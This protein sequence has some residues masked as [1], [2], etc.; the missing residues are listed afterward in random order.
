M[1]SF[2]GSGCI[3]ATILRWTANIG[4]QR[5]LRSTVNQRF[6]GHT[7]VQ[8]SSKQ[9]S[10]NAQQ[11][12]GRAVVVMGLGRFGGGVGVTR[13]LAEQGAQVTVTDLFTEDQ[14][15]DALAPLRTLIDQQR[16]T[17][18]LGGHDEADFTRADLI[19]A[20]PAVPR[21]WTN[22]YLNA[23]R[24]AGAAITTEVRLLVERLNRQRVIGV[25]GTAGKSTTAAMIHHALNR[26]GR[27][28]HLGGNIGGS[29]LNELGS[30]QDDDRIVLELSSAMLYWL[31]AGN[32]GHG[33][34]GWSP[35]CAVITNIAPNHLDWHESFEHY[36]RCK[37]NIARW[38]QTGDVLIRGDDLHD[39]V[40]PLQLAIPGPHN[41]TNARTAIAVVQSVIDVDAEA[42]AIA[43]GDFRGLPHRLQLVREANGLRVYN[44]SKSTTPEATLRAIESFDDPQ[45]IHLIAGGYDKGVDLSPIARLSS[46]LAGVYTIGQTGAAIA[47][48]AGSASNV[49]AC[50]DLQ[51]A[52]QQA[53]SRMKE[54]DLLLLSPGCASW[55][56][57]VNFEQRGDAF[58]KHVNEHLERGA[59]G[60]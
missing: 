35:S 38:Q 54:G 53:M 28:A 13:W 47:N 21:P 37:M 36:R 18:R 26:L 19:V 30:I 24:Q 11:L 5:H 23:A 59:C 55:D 45:H 39:D 15:A 4:Q 16:L 34:A 1:A 50:G 57:F 14:L 58:I 29:L 33:A 10:S 22:R 46:R 6:T 49:Q 17:L 9:R 8:C 56:Q 60:A 2:A 7:A 25:T 41:V 3:G 12:A 32:G 52:V 48:A 27:R 44:D 42:V 43:L 31:G 20:N 51:H 40:A